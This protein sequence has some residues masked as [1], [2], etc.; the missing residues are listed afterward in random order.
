MY[1]Y[2]NH[3]FE[4]GI[5]GYLPCQADTGEVMFLDPQGGF[6]SV[7][8]PWAVDA[9]DTEV[10]TYYEVRGDQIVQ[11]VVPDETT[12]YPVVADPTWITC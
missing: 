5:E 1:A 11:V 3:M 6:V 7:A 9:N 4:Y 12:A 8:A 10:A 2:L